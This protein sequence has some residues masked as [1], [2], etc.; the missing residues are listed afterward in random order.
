[1]RY[2]GYMDKP[3]WMCQFDKCTN[4][5]KIIKSTG[6]AYR[7]CSMHLGRKSRGEA[8]DG[9]ETKGRGF[10]PGHAAFGGQSH[11][12]NKSRYGTGRGDSYGLA[13]S[14]LLQ[15][16]GRADDYPCAV[17]GKDTGRR[18]W[19]FDEPVGWSMDLT[20]YAP[21]CVECH[22]RQ[23]LEML[24]AC[25]YEHHPETLQRH[26]RDEPPMTKAEAAKLGSE[27]A[28]RAKAEMSA[29]ARAELETRRG[30][31]VREA[32]ALISPEEKSARAQRIWESRRRNEASKPP[33]T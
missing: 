25:W 33:P 10:Q 20:R 7:L 5:R 12:G 32:L 26:D 6:S 27:A 29:E 24:I 31:S 21:M 8:L 14:R 19:A 13:H 22:R 17:C 4:P 3:E 16:R 15:E 30:A 2:I 18:E 23:T 9:S 28:R 1:M 11:P